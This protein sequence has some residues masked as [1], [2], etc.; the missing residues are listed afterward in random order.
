MLIQR[1]R[2]KSINLTELQNQKLETKRGFLYFAEARLGKLREEGTEGTRE[3][4]HPS[5]AFEVSIGCAV[6]ITFSGF[7]FGL[8]NY[9][10]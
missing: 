6:R 4:T 5:P 8:L 7:Y 2:G 9:F 3:R 10:D 1:Q